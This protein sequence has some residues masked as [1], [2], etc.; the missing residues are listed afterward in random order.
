MKSALKKLSTL[1]RATILR[2][3]FFTVLFLFFYLLILYVLIN[4]PA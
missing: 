3:L 1:N 2:S 4:S